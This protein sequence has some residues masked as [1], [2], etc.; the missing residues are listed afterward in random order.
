MIEG[1]SFVRA[2]RPAG[3][4]L[5]S[6]TPCSYLTP[7]VNAVISSAEIE[8]IGAANEGEAVAIACGTQLGGR[9]G[10]V[11]FQNSGLG[12]AVNPLTSL[13]AT[14]RIPLLVIATWRG[15]P[16]GPED[17]PQHELMGRITPK[18]FELMEIPWAPFPE[19]EAA[20]GPALDRALQHI[21]TSG[22]PYGLI[23]RHGV[24]A[25]APLFVQPLAQRSAR[26]ALTDP[27]PAIAALEPNEIL[28]A[29]QSTI[30]PA[31]AVLTTTGFTGR[32]L[33]AL[34]DQPNQFYMAGSMGCVSSLGLGLAKVQPRRQVIVLDG[35]G[36]LL[37]RM[38]A[39]PV[40]AHEGPP[41]LVHILLDNGVHESTGGQP[42]VSSSVDFAAIAYASGYPR[43]VGA[44][45]LGELRAALQDKCREL[46]FIHV[47]TKPRSSR[48]LPRPAI[49]AP[50]LAER[51]RTWLR[52]TL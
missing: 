20:I 25:P 6:G 4:G 39:L 51:F 19:T 23:L 44:G 8:Y 34:S 38:G 2:L 22:K 46:T 21:R 32:A 24:V 45:S 5:V 40:I 10:V 50:A 17:E 49:S 15:Q 33:Y 31:A 52:Q 9:L 13:A 37:M 12:N 30:H 48:K 26:A 47:K 14:F 3:F 16:D 35:D 42:T 11:M 41:N 18:L 29:I 7:L 28:S 1:E 36:A 27:G 43:V